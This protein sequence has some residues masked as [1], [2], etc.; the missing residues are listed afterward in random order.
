MS[1]PN[2]TDDIAKGLAFARACV[3]DQR[4]ASHRRDDR[5]WD[6]RYA[7][8]LEALDVIVRHHD[9]SKSTP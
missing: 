4:V 7:D 9:K 3:K 8:A 1:R 2:I 5:S 6:K